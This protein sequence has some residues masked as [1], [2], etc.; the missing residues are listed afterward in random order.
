MDKSSQRCLRYLVGS[1]CRLWIAVPRHPEKPSAGCRAASWSWA[2]SPSAAELLPGVEHLLLKHTKGSALSS[3]VKNEL[4]STHLWF[5]TFASPTAAGTLSA[6][7][8]TTYHNNRLFFPCL[9]SESLQHTGGWW[10]FAK[11]LAVI[12]KEAPWLEGHWRAAT[13]VISFSCA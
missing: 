12:W 1:V 6:P 4:S 7:H 13:G 2:G 8:T 10:G 3:T 11:A 9:R 5:H